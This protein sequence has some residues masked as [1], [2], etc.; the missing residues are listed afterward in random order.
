MH[1][2]GAMWRD[3]DGFLAIG[4]GDDYKTVADFDCSDMDIDE[5]EANKLRMM[6]CWNGCDGLR[7]DE[8]HS[9]VKGVEWIVYDASFKAPEQIAPEYV[10]EMYIARIQR[11]L[12]QVK[13]P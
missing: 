6:S 13:S 3:D 8:L 5:R 11:L 4:K 9:F 10:A 12:E 2:Q 1:T 7:P